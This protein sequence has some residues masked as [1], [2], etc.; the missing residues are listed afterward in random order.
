[1][2]V[3]AWVLR[4]LTRNKGCGRQRFTLHAGYESGNRYR[5]DGFSCIQ[6]VRGASGVLFSHRLL[7]DMV[8]NE[9]I[10]IFSQ[11]AGLSEWRGTLFDTRVIKLWSPL[12]RVVSSN[13]NGCGQHVR[14][15]SK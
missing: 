14:M 9:A 2:R 13:Q 8:Q 10:D 3:H 11:D 4:V 1:M 15:R 6:Q 12:D 5:T 7:R